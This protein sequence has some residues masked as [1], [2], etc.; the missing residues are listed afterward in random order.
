[1]SFVSDR[2]DPRRLIATGSALIALAFVALFAFTARAQATELIFWDNYS[3]NPDSVAF[4]DITGSGGGALNLTGGELESP[5]GMAYDTVTNRLFVGSA[6]GPKGE[7]LAINVDGSGAAPFGAPGAVIEEPEGVAV[8]PVSRTLYWVNTEG[9]GSIGWAKLDG[10]AGGVLNTSGATVSSPYKIALD[11]VNGRVY[12]ANTTPNPDTISFANVNNTGGANLDLSGAPAPVSITGLSVDPAGGRIYWLDE[13]AGKVGFASL[14]GGSGGEVNLTGSVFNGP[15]GLAFD[16]S[17]GRL[18][19]GNYN[20]GEVRA[21]AIGFAAIS[22][23]GSTI[24]PTTA[25][26]NGPQ[27][28]VII[29]DPSGTGA[30]AITRSSTDRA[31]LSCST[32]SW[33]ADFPGG[34]VYQSPRSFA[35]QWSKNG[36]AIGGATAPTFTATS[37]GSYTCAVTATNQAGTATQGSGAINV[38]AAKVKLT[39]KKKAKGEP[40]DLVTFKVKAANQGDLKPKNAKVCVKL[41]KAAKDDLKA[42]KCKSLGQ[43]KAGGKKTVT[44]K[45]KIKPGADEGTDKVTFQ[46]RGSAGKAAKSKIIVG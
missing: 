42:P 41:P 9:A 10:S 45:F 44:L 38:K 12:W 30:P 3:A 1:M 39:T 21:G 7:I 32:G 24:S 6:V 31:A 23:G 8:D 2:R 20:N 13:S 36:A 43:L 15:Y 25:P 19:W 37:P 40:G 28:P 22:G 46:V 17:I 34:F 11:V 4:S 33:G 26:V 16:P 14:G 35:Y 18:Y 29:K 27:D 5:E